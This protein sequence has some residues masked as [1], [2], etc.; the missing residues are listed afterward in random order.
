MPRKNKWRKVLGD[1]LT[2][3]SIVYVIFL[4]IFAWV[5][6]SFFWKMLLWGIAF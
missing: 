3:I 4:S 2:E 5:N 1:I 6:K